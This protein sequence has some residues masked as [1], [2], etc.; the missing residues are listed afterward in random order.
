[1]ERG[2]RLFAQTA[3]ADG[4]LNRTKWSRGRVLWPSMRTRRRRDAEIYAYGQS[5]VET[6]THESEIHPD[7][8]PPIAVRDP[9][10]VGAL[11]AAAPGNKYTYHELDDYTDLLRAHFCGRRK[12]HASIARA[13]C[14]NRFIW[15]IRRSGW[16][17]TDCSLPT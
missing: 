14:P 5:Y 6:R 15:I 16:R 13:S 10:Q 9:S 1:M 11:V 7:T 2:L 17:P 3:E 12:F 8:W 4:V